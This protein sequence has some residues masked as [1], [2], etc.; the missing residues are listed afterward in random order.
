MTAGTRD[1]RRPCA[2]GR[3]RQP[4]G[5]RRRPDRRGGGGRQRGRRTCR[6]RMR[7]RQLPREATR[8]RSAG[9][10]QI[11]V[12]VGRPAGAGLAVHEHRR[13]RRRRIRAR[14]PRT[15]PTACSAQPA[16]DHR[17]R[18][19]CARAIR[20]AGAGTQVAV[21]PVRGRRRIAGGGPG[22]RDLPRD[23]DAVHD[24]AR[25]KWPS[26]S[27]ARRST[28]ARTRHTSGSSLSALLNAEQGL[29]P[30]RRG[31]TPSRRGGYLAPP[32]ALVVKLVDTLS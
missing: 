16:R 9:T 14:R 31:L 19:G 15:C 11:D 6:S 20:W 4:G 23:V 26:P 22:R 3:V 5:R 1:R 29:L 32:H 25:C 17:A 2:P 13:G 10:D 28:G 21:T 18:G 12:R 8:P 30:S 7:R 27:T 24:R